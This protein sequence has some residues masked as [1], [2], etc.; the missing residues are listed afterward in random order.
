LPFEGL[1]IV[2]FD[3]AGGDGKQLR[4][5]CRTIAPRSRDQLETFG[6]P[7]NGDGLD[8]AVVTNARGQL[9]QLAF[10]K[11]APRV[12]GGFADGVDGEVLECA[13]VDDLR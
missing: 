13:A 11:S 6:V 7:A 9:L 5:L 8:D 2:D 1:C 4:Q 3:D 10:I 12:G